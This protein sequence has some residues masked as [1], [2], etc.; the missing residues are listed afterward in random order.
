MPLFFLYN[1]TIFL[2]SIKLNIQTGI[3]S[4]CI[5]KTTE[6]STSKIMYQI[7]NSEAFR[8]NVVEMIFDICL[9][10]NFANRVAA[11]N[12]EKGI[13]NFAIKEATNQKIVKKWSNPYFVQLYKDK[14][15]T[16]YTNLKTTPRLIQQMQSED[17]L[18]QSIPF[19]THQEIRPDQWQELIEKKIKREESKYVNRVEASTD[20]YQCRKCKSRKCTYYSVQIRSADEPMTVFISCLSCGKNWKN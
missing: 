6:Q 7:Q 14:L 15:R 2:G 12:I 16:V 18:P 17:I 19:M 8:E 9:K 13:Y 20:I 10:D 5:F 4:F 11:I 3:N 1:L